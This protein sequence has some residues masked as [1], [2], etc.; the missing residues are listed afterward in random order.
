MTERLS[1]RERKKIE[2]ARSIWRVALELFVEH[3]FDNVSVAQI[4]AA[5]NV[6]KMTVFNYFGTKEDLVLGPMEEHLGEL[7][8]VV[9]ERERGESVVAAV[10]RHF[11]A[12][13]ADFD[14]ASGLNDQTGV[15]DVQ[16]LVRQTPA[17]AQRAHDFHNRAQEL[18]AA[19]LV[20]EAGDSDPTTARVV[21]ALLVAARRALVAENHRRLLAGESA[22]QVLPDAITAADNAFELLERG[23][24]DYG[25]RA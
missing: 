22:D 3:G 20:T 5:S 16:R 21:A 4:A 25:T 1:L 9:R 11:R 2:T 23:L 15:L 24:G 6:S 13:L 12:A 7:A 8:A 14:P 18:L 17:L 19:E 10:R